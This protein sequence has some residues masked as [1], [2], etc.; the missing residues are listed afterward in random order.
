MVDTESHFVSVKSVF[1]LPNGTFNLLVKD[2]NFPNYFVTLRYSY[3]LKFK[4]N[5]NVGF[6]LGR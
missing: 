4:V 1:I 3:I 5:A 6:T 2:P